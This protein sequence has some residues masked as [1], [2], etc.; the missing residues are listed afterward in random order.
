[1]KGNGSN[2]TELKPS[3][4]CTLV[5]CILPLQ[6]FFSCIYFY[7][8]WLSLHSL[9]FRFVLSDSLIIKLFVAEDN[10]VMFGLNCLHLHSTPLHFLMM[11]P[12]PFNLCST[13]GLMMQLPIFMKYLSLLILWFF[14]VGRRVEIL[15]HK[16][17][18]Y[19][20]R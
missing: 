7:V 3:F 14:C 4:L 15:R 13:I 18:D 8:Q 6:C 11:A 5:S 1:M 17:S 20:G 10:L 19:T 9:S 12:Q 16:P 2:R